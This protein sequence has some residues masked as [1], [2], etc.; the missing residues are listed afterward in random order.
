MLE[1]CSYPYRTGLNHPVYIHWLWF[2]GRRRQDV[3]SF[4]PS[5]ARCVKSLTEVIIRS[6][7]VTMATGQII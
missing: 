2:P 5:V 4:D 7:T 6:T 1:T 3:I